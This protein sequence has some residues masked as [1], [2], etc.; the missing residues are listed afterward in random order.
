MNRLLKIAGTEGRV[1]RC[2]ILH[3]KSNTK[4]LAKKYAK[5][6][7]LNKDV[8]PTIEALENAI[9]FSYDNTY[10]VTQYKKAGDYM[11]F[12]SFPMSA[13]Q[14][15]D[16]LLHECYHIIIDDISRY[17]G[18]NERIRLSKDEFTVQCLTRLALYLK[19]NRRIC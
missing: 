4:A 13:M 19:G 3:P 15:Q 16:T 10:A 2:C 7:V 6:I 18:K 11:V 14:L 5:H 12:F 8:R 9:K 17:E 1:R